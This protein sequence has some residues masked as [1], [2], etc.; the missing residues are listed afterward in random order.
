MSR[1]IFYALPALYTIFLWWFSTGAIIVIYGRRPA[2]VQMWFAGATLTML[3]AWAGLVYTRDLLTPLGV[4]AAF[5]C[6]TVVWGWLL[7][8]YYLGYITGR[9]P[10]HPTTL[11]PGELRRLQRDPGQRFRLGVQAS[12]YHEL[13]V[14]GVLL[15]LG[16]LLWAA[17]NRW[18]LW[19][20]VTLWLMHVSSKLNVFFGVR[21]F[22][23]E[24]L[25]PHLHG[26]GVL[27]GRGPSNGFFPFAVGIATVAALAMFAQ[28][29]FAPILPAHAIGW[30]LLGWMVLLGVI[31]QWLLVLPLPATLWGWQLRALPP[32]DPVDDLAMEERRPTS[33]LYGVPNGASAPTGE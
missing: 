1:L 23:I 15:L 2:A 11:R 21:N 6:A 31:E 24:F 14:V 9:E 19:T 32:S 27:L 12:L 4:Y 18:G 3:A 28:A 10:A 13:M 22:H 8:T 30:M 26:L 20:F 16:A 17:E 29:I 33:A 5:T 7:G 25:P